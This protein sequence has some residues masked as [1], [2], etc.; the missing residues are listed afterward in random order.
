[1]EQFNNSS[2]IKSDE[3]SKLPKE[4]I[5]APEVRPEKE[6][7]IAEFKE[8]I[9]KHQSEIDKQLQQ[10]RNLAKFFY[11][12]FYNKNIDKAKYKEN[13]PA[14]QKLAREYTA[15]IKIIRENLLREAQKE[16]NLM[17]ANDNYWL[18]CDINGGFFNKTA[19]GKFY[20]N[21]KP[22]YVGRIFLK[23]IR[24]F[25]KA[26]LHSSMKIPTIGN[27]ATFNRFDKMVIYFNPEEE[28]EVLRALEN[29]YSNNLEAFDKTG[30]PRFT[31]EIKNQKGEKMVG[32]G[33]GEEPPFH[34]E[35]FGTIRAKILA[36]IYLKA[37]KSHNSILNPDFDFESTFR[38]ICTNYQV[39]P[40]NPAFNLRKDSK[41]FSE[42]KKRI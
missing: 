25:S 36:D 8:Y 5:E 12:N 17:L 16:H 10:G 13:D 11:H 2:F 38:R 27:V 23:T 15:Q 19:L 18:Y 21:L 37:R 41:N 24:E 6:R 7:A 29:I 32:V 14:I 4:Q 42:L 33:F 35:S 20:L 31:A 26:G 39:D 40:Q 9:K 30:I 28:R 1:M 34:N 3:K 22:E